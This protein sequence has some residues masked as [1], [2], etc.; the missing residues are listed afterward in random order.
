[1]VTAGLYHKV[2]SS[3]FTCYCW[4]SLLVCITK[5]TPDVLH[6]T[7]D[8]HCWFV[9]QSGLQT[10]YMLLLMVT[11]GL[12]HKVD[13]SHFTCYSWW[14]LLVCITKWTPDVLHVTV[15][16]HC[17]FVSQGGLEPFYM[18]L[19]VVTAGLYHKVD[20]SHFTCYS[21]W[22]LL[23]CITKW[24]RAIL[25]VTVD[26]HYWFVSQGG[27][28]PFYMLQLMVTTSLYHKVDSSHFTCYCWWSLLV[29]IT[30]WSPAIFTCYSW[31]SLL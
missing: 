10:F 22:S 12:Y 19:L 13:S 17:W 20:S 5:W 9:S 26:G 3:H 11:A 25:H 28:Q 1:M 31:W 2:D 7:V 4:W 16:G 21:W 15:D 24:T 30:K 18:L 23:V 27:L 6:V 8:G 14:S 29:C